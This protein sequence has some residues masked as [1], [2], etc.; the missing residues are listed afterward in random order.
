MSVVT[1]ADEK[2]LECKSK[3]DDAYKALLFVLNPDTYGHDELKDEYILNVEKVAIAI[4][5]LKREL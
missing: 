2:I 1:T 3:L 4:L 5:S